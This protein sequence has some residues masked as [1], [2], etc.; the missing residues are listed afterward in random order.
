MHYYVAHQAE[1]HAELL[2]SSTYAGR[3]PFMPIFQVS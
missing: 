2:G 1:I 3:S